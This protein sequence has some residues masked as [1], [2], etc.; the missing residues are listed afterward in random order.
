M[1]EMGGKLEIYS[2]VVA[3]SILYVNKTLR[4]REAQSYLCRASKLGPQRRRGSE[5]LQ[6]HIGTASLT[7]ALHCNVGDD[8]GWHR[9]FSA[10]LRR[11]DWWVGGSGVWGQGGDLA[12][13]PNPKPV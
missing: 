11:G 12:T 4:S 9:E 3:T 10:P 2:A 7:L 8:S 5:A 13:R 1:D 6:A